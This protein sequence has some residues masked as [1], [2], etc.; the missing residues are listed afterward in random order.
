MEDIMEI[1][2]FLEDSGLLLKSVTEKIQKETTTKKQKQK[3]RFIG[4]LL[5]TLGTFIREVY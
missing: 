3:G 1:V 5:G 2:K 4:M